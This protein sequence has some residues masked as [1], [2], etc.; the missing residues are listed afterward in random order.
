MLAELARASG[1]E[2]VE[3]LVDAQTDL[4]AAKAS[5]AAASL[6]TLLW[7]DVRQMNRVRRRE[8][9]HALFVAA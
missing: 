4:P 1:I 5:A 7:L 6:E 9:L 8:V 2:R 3:A